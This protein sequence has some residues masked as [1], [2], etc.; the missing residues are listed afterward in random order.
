MSVYSFGSYRLDASAGQLRRG[1]EVVPLAPKAFAVLQHL[2][3]RAGQLVTK[4]ELLSVA[5]ADVH[6]GDGALKV[7]VREIRRALADDP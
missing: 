3:D 5:W 2:A 4:D 6:V 1:E 7:C